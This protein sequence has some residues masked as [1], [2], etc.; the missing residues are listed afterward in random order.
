MRV[1]LQPSGAVGGDIFHRSL[2]IEDTALFEGSSRR[3]ENPIEAPKPAPR[4]QLATA[5]GAA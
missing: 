3:V 1:K 2:S 4:S 5:E